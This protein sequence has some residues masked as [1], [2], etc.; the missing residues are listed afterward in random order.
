MESVSKNTLAREFVRPDG[1]EEIIV[2]ANSGLLPTAACPAT[3]KEIFIK[4]TGPNASD[5][6]YR[7]INIDRRTGALAT[8]QTPPEAIEEKKI[9]I[10]PPDAVPW[11]QEKIIE[12]PGSEYS[13]LGYATVI[14]NTVVITY[15]WS[16]GVARA[17]TNT[18]YLTPTAP[19]TIGRP[20]TTGISIT[21]TQPI[22]RSPDIT[23]P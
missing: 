22:T 17:I 12:Q 11:A 13:G 14:S 15:P 7:T 8:G 21:S 20:I 18:Q 3:T 23:I 6:I 2:C 16:E 10:L 4:G 9:V 1:L 5:S 19:I